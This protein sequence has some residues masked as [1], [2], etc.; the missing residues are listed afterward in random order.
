MEQ[1][2]DYGKESELV[3][4]LTHLNDEDSLSR[5]AYEKAY[6]GYRTGMPFTTCFVLSVIIRKDQYD[7]RVRQLAAVLVR[8]ILEDDKPDTCVWYKMND[9]V[10]DNLLGEILQT[11]SV[12]AST[13]D[14]VKHIGGV[15]TG[16][17][18]LLAQA[19]KLQLEIMKREWPQMFAALFQLSQSRESPQRKIAYD[20]FNKIVEYAPSAT[21]KYCTDIGML[22][23]KGLQDESSSAV[24]LSAL[25]AFSS[26]IV[27]LETPEELE[28]FAAALPTMLNVLANALQQLLVPGDNNNNN[29][30][31]SE[32]NEEACQKSLLALVDVMAQHP[33][34]LKKHLQH[35][36]QFMLFVG[37]C[38]SF[39]TSTRL[40][41]FEFMI[42]TCEQLPATMKKQYAAF[43]KNL[44]PC[45]MKLIHEGM[46][47]EADVEAWVNVLDSTAIELS[48]GD[49][50]LDDMMVR[51]G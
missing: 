25:S 35:A 48:D 5:N 15:R 23:G 21:R 38:T 7:T 17:I 51:A 28:P 29:V 27:S 42:S 11:F 43:S 16:S 4:I 20:T 13:Q 1:N 22:L 33:K 3:S 14:S 49:E 8:R 31:S 34:F 18:H 36:L 46:D 24:R 37:E 41:A 45:C 50:N 47:P 39:E 12:L 32:I 9:D 40:L 44:I 26:M 30:L 10:K 19:A 6:S 2:V